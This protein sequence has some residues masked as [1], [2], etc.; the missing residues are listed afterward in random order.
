MTS[1]DINRLALK[2]FYETNKEEYFHRRNSGD[3]ELW[4]EQYKWKILPELNSAFKDIARVT[5]ESIHGIIN[6]LHK[7]NP[8]KGSF[9]HWIELDNLKPFADKP[10][11]YNLINAAWQS[12][13]ENIGR[14]I[15]AANSLAKN[16]S[17]DT[18]FGPATWGFILAAKNCDK[19]ALYHDNIMKQLAELNSVNKLVEV[20]EKYQLL[21]GSALY[22]GELMQQ[23]KLTDRLEY[24]AL[25]GQDF[26][27]VINLAKG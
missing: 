2:N 3:S 14:N 23:D 4:D 13:T 5:P 21:N 24:Q 19:F 6:T 26:F 18:K 10:F 15:D 7:N 22:V 20:G 11:S 12:S 16:L 17:S 9:T 8:N 25:N 1:D 27:W